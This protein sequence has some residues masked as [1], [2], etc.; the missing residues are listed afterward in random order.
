MSEHSC[1]GLNLLSEDLRDPKLI[2]T[3]TDKRCVIVCKFGYDIGLPEAHS[4][5]VLG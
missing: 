1:K 3:L 5:G 4:N 2:L